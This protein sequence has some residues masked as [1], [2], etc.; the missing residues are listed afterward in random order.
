MDVLKLT[1]ALAWK[2]IKIKYKNSLLGFVWSLINPLLFL[3]VFS[4]VFGNAF[5]NIQNYKLYALS[6]LVIWSFF[7]VATNQIIQSVIENASILRSIH[8]RPHVFTFSALISAITNFL[9]T[10]V[11]FAVIMYFLD[12]RPTVHLVLFPVL[13]LLYG[14][15]TYGFSLFMCAVN[16][17]FRDIGLLWNTLLPAIFYFTPIAYPP[18]LI[19]EAYRWIIELNPVFHYVEFFRD[20]VYEPQWPENGALGKMACI[21]FGFWALGEFVFRKLEN[22]FYANY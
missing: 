19:P 15:F 21:A 17:Y 20:M 14:V 3:L 22:G 1:W 11:P 16:V 8:I 10:L 9:F 4:F 6:G 5:S 2:N 18:D 12:F 7:P 13:L